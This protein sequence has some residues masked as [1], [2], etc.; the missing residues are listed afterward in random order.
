MLILSGLV[1]VTNGAFERKMR[2]KREKSGFGIFLENPREVEKT[3][4]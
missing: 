4:V 3:F 2:E 1:E